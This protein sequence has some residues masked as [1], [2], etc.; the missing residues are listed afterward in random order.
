[1]SI[2]S[3]CDK[4]VTPGLFDIRLECG[5]SV[6]PNCLDPKNPNFETCRKYPNCK[7]VTILEEPE[8]IDGR[9][10]INNPPNNLGIVARMKRV[11]TKE[12]F[13]SIAKKTSVPLLKEKGYHLQRCIA[14]GVLID[15]FLQA[16]YTWQELKNFKALSGAQGK[17]RARQALVALQCNAE[18]FRD[19]KHLLDTTMQDLD[20]NARHMVELYGIFFPDTEARVIVSNGQNNPKRPW[21]AEDFIYFGFK[22]QDLFGAGMKFIEHYEA[23]KPTDADDEHFGLNDD[24]MTMLQPLNPPK[25][26]PVVP[27]A[28]P[29]VAV[30]PAVVP[31][32][33]RFPVVTEIEVVKKPHGLRKK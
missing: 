19:Y 29:A 1:M 6:H 15:D 9:D 17:E 3:Y 27:V 5:C 11:V 2:C 26:K 21:R 7:T 24:D 13:I 30:P 14:D 12:P 10:Y 8:S 33:L 18:H 31:L 4:I 16:G 23:L 32:H 25:P 20:I 28:A 22:K